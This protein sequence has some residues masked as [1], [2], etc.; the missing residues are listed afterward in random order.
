L[1]IGY[2]AF[3]IE[4][5]FELPPRRQAAVGVAV[6]LFFGK[7]AQIVG[8]ERPSASLRRRSLSSASGWG[9]Q[10]REIIP[11]FSFDAM[12][13]L[14]LRHAHRRQ[15]IHRPRGRLAGAV[16]ATEKSPAALSS[17]R[18]GEGAAGF[19]AIW[20]SLLS[21]SG[22]PFSAGQSRPASQLARP[23]RERAT[24]ARSPQKKRPARFSWLLPPGCRAGRESFSGMTFCSDC[25]RGACAG[26]VGGFEMR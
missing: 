10:L 11:A 23:P 26:F 18:A 22:A 20:T 6:Q 16:F 1:T 13:P 24:A 15:Q 8:G 7:H 9:G 17:G 21:G 5:R 3:V 25:G 14:W 19:F 2:C 12:R 4:L